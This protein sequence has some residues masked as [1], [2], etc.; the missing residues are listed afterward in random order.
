MSILHDVTTYAETQRW[1]AE[2]VDK[3]I[4]ELEA[5]VELIRV[6][7]D[8]RDKAEAEV[9]RLKKHGNKLCDSL[10]ELYAD[11]VETFGPHVQESKPHERAIRLVVAW[12]ER[13]GEE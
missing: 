2:K 12:R 6:A 3:R 4:A 9:D 1:R 7:F 10:A 5:E 8:Q 13:Y 11:G